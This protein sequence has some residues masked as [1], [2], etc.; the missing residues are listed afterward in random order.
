MLTDTVDMPLT[1]RLEI[2]LDRYKYRNI[3]DKQATI[4][5]K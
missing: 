1:P 5:Y 2:E 4:N 3:L